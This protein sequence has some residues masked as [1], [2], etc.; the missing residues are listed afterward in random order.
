MT[1]V[2]SLPSDR[3]TG[4]GA[5][6]HLIAAVVP[7]AIAFIAYC[8]VSLARHARF[9]SGSWDMGCHVHNLWLLSHPG[10]PQISSVLGDAH[11]WGGTNHFMPSLVLAVPLAPVVALTGFTGILLVLQAAVIAAAVVPLALLAHRRG[12][13]PMTIAGLS[14]AYLFHVGTQTTVSFDVHET[15]A[16]PLFMLLAIWAFEADKRVVAYASLLLL[17]GLKESAIV[18]A[19]GVGLWLAVSTRGKRIEG[20]AIFVAMLAW[21]FVVTELIQPAFLEEGSA[22]MIHVARFKA[23]GTGPL[24]MAKHVLFHPIDTVSLLF[25][26]APKGQTLAITIGGFAFLPFIAPEALVLAGPTLAERFLSD[27]REMWSL[28]F[29]YSLPLIGAWAFASV[30]A[31]ARVRDI[32]ARLPPR[33]F[34]IGAGVVLVGALVASHLAAPFPPEL[35]SVQKPYM[36]SPEDVSRYRRALAVVPDDA[37]VVAQNHFLP[38]LAYRQFI[39]QPHRRYVERADVVVLDTKASPWPHGPRHVRELVESLRADPK[40]SVAFEEQSTVV[41][42]RE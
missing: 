19:A 36:A 1:P 28:G 31:L 14:L 26:P 27:K 35:A 25:T 5:H 18:Y 29:H 23:L 10:A 17:A 20:G 9:G 12:L 33:A 2:K 16:V 38:H 8:V 3:P 40:W 30:A 6:A 22:G 41:F 7:A 32:A 34:D 42:K 37:K 4:R 13:G 24:E 15:T 21:F 39:W 11:F